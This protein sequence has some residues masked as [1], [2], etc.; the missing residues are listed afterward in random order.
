MQTP[1]TRHVG[2][3][4]NQNG[5]MCDFAGNS[6]ICPVP[7]CSATMRKLTQLRNTIARETW[8]SHYAFL[9]S[10]SYHMTVFD[11]ICDQVRE[12][13]Y[14]TRALGL[15]ST[16]PEIDTFVIDR[17]L[18]LAPPPV[19]IMRFQALVIGEMV[20][21]L[22]KPDDDQVNAQLHAYRNL[23]AEAF[24]IRHP[25]HDNYVFHITL[26]Y[27]ITHLAGEEKKAVEEKMQLWNEVLR[28]DLVLI[29]L[30]PPRLTFF[31][32]MTHFSMRRDDAKQQVI[33]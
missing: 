24:E 9:P 32:N 23:L 30:L 1:F 2:Q 18:T 8:Q 26:A 7:A 4:F 11:L 28:K 5:S 19:L 29:D 22:L 6:I 16:L 15:D 3:K 27:G 10:S 14:W 25:N 31:Q 17:W 13:E 33:A 21:I 20:T 12:P